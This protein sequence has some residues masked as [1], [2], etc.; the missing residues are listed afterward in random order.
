MTCLHQTYHT[1]RSHS[2]S[3]HDHTPHHPSREPH[4]PK[5]EGRI[6]PPNPPPKRP[7]LEHLLHRLPGRDA[8]DPTQPEP[9]P[10]TTVQRRRRDG[11]AQDHDARVQH[12]Q[13]RRVGV[14]RRWR[15]GKGPDKGERGREQADQ[16][17]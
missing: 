17:R 9:E 1:S 3:Q 13:Q 5:D 15:L 7:L 4:A 14:P 2:L 11:G 10:A 6:H 16:K 12:A 8:H